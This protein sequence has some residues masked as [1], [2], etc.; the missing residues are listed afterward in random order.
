MSI[1]QTSSS[2]RWEQAAHL[3][4]RGDTVTIAVIIPTLNE[5]SVIERTLQL[6]RQLGFEE[7][8]V[9]DG[10]ST[11]RTNVVVDTIAGHPN[12]G[13]TPVRRLTAP[14]GRSRQLNAG[15]RS[16][17][18]DVLLFLHADSHLP[19]DAK[20]LIECALADPEVAG[21]RFD[22]RFDRPSMWGRI[23]SLFMN[24]RSRLSRISTGDQAM[25]VRRHVF[26]QLDGF[27]D[28]PIME[29]I[30]FSARLK[31]T[32]HTVALRSYVTTSFRRWERQG[33]LR[34]ILLMWALRF[35]YWIGISPHR[36]ARLYAD[37]R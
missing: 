12:A 22:L 24:L 36:L 2:S 34:T 23:I 35:L 17:R 32:G 11:D 19:V 15:A 27:P 4:H 3:G 31:R 29:D 6:T 25:F 18:Q 5:A 33:P 1:P 28:I 26:Q 8:I 37:V 7:I 10:G 13:L 30:E 21:G 16:C 9:V 20:W 14:A